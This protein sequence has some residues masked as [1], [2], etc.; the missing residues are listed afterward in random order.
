[1]IKRGYFG[2]AL[3][4]FL[5]LGFGCALGTKVSQWKVQGGPNECKEMCRIWD[6]EFAGMVGVG[7]QGRTTDGASACICQVR[8]S[9]PNAQ[10]GAAGA[11]AS[12]AAPISAVEAAA[13]AAEAARYSTAVRV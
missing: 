9:A 12:M 8:K 5:S 11:A 3:F 7:D 2:L 13:A 10:T 6:L 4:A 1:M